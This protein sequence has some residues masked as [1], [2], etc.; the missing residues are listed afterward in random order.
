[1]AMRII[2]TIVICAVVL[3]LGSCQ[4][5]EYIFGSV[6]PTTLMLAKAQV[7]LS[8]E[9]VSGSGSS[10][11]V[12]V[13]EL[14]GNGYVVVEGSLP[15]NERAFFFYDLDLK[16]KRSLTLPST[17]GNGVMVDAAGLSINAGGSMLDPASL[18]TVGSGISVSYNGTAGNDGFVTTGH[19]I[20]GFNIQNGSILNYSVDGTLHTPLP[21]LSTMSNLGIDAVLDDGDPAG[22][23]IFVV[24]QSGG[25]NQDDA[26]RYFVTIPKSSFTGTVTSYLL[27]SA[28]HRDKLQRDSLGFAN[29]SI[30][31]YDRGSSRYVRINP[32]T[33]SI[34]D[35]L[36]SVNPQD[37]RFAYRVSGGEFYGFNTKNRVLTKYTAWW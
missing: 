7:D 10:F 22:N 12:R 36:Y 24:S 17:S 2:R 26:T 25:D 13:V 32:A 8:A 11:N 18:A 31:A 19:N 35:S 29:G 16:L 33:G 14:G 3:F 28:P 9:I 6:F 27:D 21:T 37:T 30:I 15:T 5:F 4:V 34:Q 1:M 23:A 20:T